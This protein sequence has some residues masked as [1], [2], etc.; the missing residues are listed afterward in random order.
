M[1]ES[2]FDPKLEEIWDE[3]G[4]TEPERDLMLEEIEQ[5]CLE[6]YRRKLD[7]AMKCRA[8]IQQEIAKIRAE[9]SDICLALGE[10]PPHFVWKGDGGLKNELESA[11]PQLEEM[12]K[13]KIER[14]NKFFE[15]VDQ[16]EKISNEIGGSI[17][18]GLHK[19]VADETDLSFNK[20]EELRARLLAYQ[21]E[22]RDRQKQVEDLLSTLNL[23][24]LV[25]GVDFKHTIYVI[26][27]TLNDSVGVKDISDNTI[28]S[29]TSAV[30]RL[31]EVKMKRWK[32]LQN[33]ATALLEMW[34][35]MDIPMVEQTLFHNV[36]SKIAASISEIT[37]TN[38]LSVKFLN[39]V[40]AEVSRLEQL[41]SRKLRHLVMKKR[42]ELDEIC[43]QAH[44]IAE[45]HGATEFSTEAIESESLDPECLL[46]QIEL[47]IARAKD[48]ALSRK[49][50]LEKVEKWLAACQE[51]CWLEEYNKDDKRYHAG[52]G[53]HL[54]LKRA[55]KARAMINKIPGTTSFYARTV[56]DLEARE[57]ARKA[58]A[59]STNFQSFIPDQKKLRGQLIVEM[60]AL[61]GTKPSPSSSGKKGL[62]TT[63][64]GAA[65]ASRKLSL[66]GAMLQNSKPEKAAPIRH[67]K[68]AGSS[69]QKSSIRSQQNGGF[70]AS[71]S[72]G[73]RS[74]QFQGHSPVIR[75]PFSPVSSR[76]LSKANIAN[77]L[78]DCNERPQ[79]E[80]AI[81]QR[82]LVSI[83]EYDHEPFWKTPKKPIFVGDE[84]RTPST[85]PIPML[86]TPPSTPPTPIEYS[87]EEVRA[88][89]IRP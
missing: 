75:K 88:G 8:Q 70:G 12:R 78:E 2:R 3:V 85:M 28:K 25:L 30:V 46:A 44:M 74:S 45:E 83:N 84:N 47:Q 48:E 40:E 49:E 41:R 55:E 13:R 68:K 11:V 10:Q 56:R 31:S 66:S 21:D 80:R 7:E 51:E 59:E 6:V 53:S 29:L 34:N 60:E 4:E 1:I 42:L 72:S 81:M 58:K 82:K 20:L 36:T 15:V 62:K 77:P 5:K 32:K 52:R 76:A 23:L 50:I 54:S 14:K 17:E 64:T 39:H 43:R 63:V 19:M 38:M 79:K 18:E 61:Y 89:F 27:P 22:K 86:N 67:P 26:H 16:L 73:K 71:P 57:R 24:C 69:N 33:L 87:F 35:L 37:E 9:I 65:S